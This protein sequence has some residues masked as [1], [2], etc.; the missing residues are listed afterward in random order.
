[1]LAENFNFLE[2]TYESSLVDSGL[3]HAA[4]GLVMRRRV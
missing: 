4:L 1:M 3:R 2:A